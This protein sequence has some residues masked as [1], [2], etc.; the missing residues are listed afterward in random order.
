MGA[1]LIETLGVLVRQQPRDY[2]E[3]LFFADVKQVSEFGKVTPRTNYIRLQMSGIFRRL[4]ADAKPLAYVVAESCSAPLTCHVPEPISGNPR[5]DPKYQVHKA[6][7]PY[8]QKITNETHPGGE[9]GFFNCPYSLKK[10]LDETQLVLFHRS[11]TRREILLFLSNK[12][13]GIH[14][15]TVLADIGAGGKSV[16]ALTLWEA[17]ERVNLFGQKALF[18]QFDNVCAVLWRALAPLAAEIHERY[19]GQVT[20]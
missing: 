16:D 17:N 7:A 6:L 9:K 18:Q 19:R 3:K 14:A 15:D 12:M 10:Y 5:Y 4:V 11:I 8:L 2:L 20:L 13:G 1:R